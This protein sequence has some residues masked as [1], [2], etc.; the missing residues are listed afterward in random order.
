MGLLKEGD[1]EQLRIEFEKL[2]N[3]VKLVFFTQ[4]LECDYCPLTQQVLEE[5]VGL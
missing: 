4:A 3:P 5:V 2:S 1:R